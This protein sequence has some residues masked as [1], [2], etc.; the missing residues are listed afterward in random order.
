MTHATNDTRWISVALA[1]AC[2]PLAACIDVL[3]GP[4]YRARM[5]GVASIDA[6]DTIDVRDVR[7]VHRID[8]VDVPRDLPD[9]ADADAML[10]DDVIEQEASFDD[11]AVA[12]V[13]VIEDVPEIPCAS[14]CANGQT[15]CAGACVNT[16]NNEQNCG[17][18]GRVCPGRSVCQGGRCGT[19]FLDALPCGGEQRCCIVTLLCASILCP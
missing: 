15:C 14:P 3:D 19:C 2:A 8:R 9:E 10:V 18:C 7:D 13:I 6:V 16:A 17:G 4:V 12:D 11:G 5:D 1:I